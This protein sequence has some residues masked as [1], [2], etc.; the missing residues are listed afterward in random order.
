M[1]S[2]YEKESVIK[3]L[4]TLLIKPV[5][6]LFGDKI[7]TKVKSFATERLNAVKN[8]GFILP[9]QALKGQNGEEFNDYF[10]LK[11]NA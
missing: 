11:I 3:E 6:D 10:V 8:L 2:D 7:V 4:L 1:R 9:E 5:Y